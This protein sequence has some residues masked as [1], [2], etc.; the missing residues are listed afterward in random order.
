MEI[1][2]T[3]IILVGAVCVLLGF[4]ASILINSLSEENEIPA[5]GTDATPPGGRKGRYT[6]VYRIWREKGSGILVVE[7]DGKSM[8]TPAS[9]NEVQRE[10][11]ERSAYDLRAW[12]GMSPAGMPASQPGDVAL[13]EAPGAE[14]GQVIISAPASRFSK[15]A[16]V[17]LP[18]ASK[19]KEEPVVAPVAKSIVLQIEDILKDKIAGTELA[20]RGVHLLEDPTRGVLVQVGLEQFEGIEAV[21]DPQIKGII[22]SAVQEWEKSR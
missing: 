18:P 20:Q 12:L 15:P 1:S 16:A 19:V 8:I 5:E 7:M 2:P 3:T 9:L 22:K 4:L 17:S 14:P 13:P 11:L 21:P 6:P 10:R